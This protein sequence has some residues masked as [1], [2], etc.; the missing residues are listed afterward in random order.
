MKN[1][2]DSLEALRHTVKSILLEHKDNKSL[3]DVIG[4]QSLESA[5]SLHKA[6]KE[7]AGTLDEEQKSWLDDGQKDYLS[8]DERMI[9]QHIYEGKHIDEPIIWFEGG[10]WVN[11]KADGMLDLYAPYLEMVILENQFGRRLRDVE[12]N[13]ILDTHKEAVGVMRC[14]ENITKRKYRT[15]I[16]P[17]GDKESKGSYGLVQ[18]I[19]EFEAG[20]ADETNEFYALD[21]QRKRR[22]YIKQTVHNWRFKLHLKLKNNVPK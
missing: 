5:K 14:L 19:E 20:Q 11:L 1:K 16:D 21:R 8:P 6:L 22:N 12:V 10:N 2:I 15:G 13:Q 9:A 7:E 18:Q 4:P 3:Y 17:I